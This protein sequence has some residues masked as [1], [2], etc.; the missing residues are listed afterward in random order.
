LAEEDLEVISNYLNT[1]A[2]DFNEAHPGIS[3]D[4]TF[5]FLNL[6]NSRLNLLYNNGGVGLLLVVISLA[7]FLSF[8]LSLWV[9]FG[10][11]ASFLGMFIIANLAG[12]T[13][14][15]ISLFGMILVIG[16]LVDDG[17]VIGENIFTH[18][19]RGKSPKQAAL[20]GTIEVM[21]AVLTSVTTTIVA[22]APLLFL[23][24]QMEMLY[25]MA[26]IVIFSLAF[27][28]V[29]AFFILPAHLSS[30]SVLKRVNGTKGRIAKILE[31]LI[32]FLRD[33]TYK[34]VLKAV[35]RWRWIVVVIPIALILITAGMIQG[36]LIRTTFFPS[37]AFDFFAVDL[38]F[39]PGSGE[40]QTF[41]YLK[42]FEEKI[43]EVNE[44]M[45]TLIPTLLLQYYR[46]DQLF[47]DK[48]LE[49]MRE[50]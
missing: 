22:F 40:K 12:I 43:W 18:F 15:M 14:N 6:L 45:V 26:F 23:V 50:Q 42:N 19:E 31:K 32:F 46:L 41:E 39:T 28:L 35:I 49:V 44:E 17:I 4:I 7:M 21:P 30:N 47:R 25:E 38:A 34:V 9:A 37:I 5:D 3:F 13:I 27:S 11:P 36:T 16:I 2:E 33:K 8:R 20:D 48:R 24:G 1:Y 10:I 29:E